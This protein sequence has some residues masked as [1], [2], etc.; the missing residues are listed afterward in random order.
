MEL[1][2]IATREGRAKDGCVKDGRSKDGHVNGV[3]CE[4]MTLTSDER[5]PVSSDDVDSGKASN[6]EVL[7]SSNE[8]SKAP[9]VRL[10]SFHSRSLCDSDMSSLG[11][12]DLMLGS[13]HLSDQS[14]AD[15]HCSVRSGQTKDVRRS[16]VS[17]SRNKKTGVQ[18]DVQHDLTCVRTGVQQL[19]QA[20][21][22]KTG[23][24]EDCGDGVDIPAITDAFHYRPTSERTRHRYSLP[25]D[26]RS[27]LHFYPS[28]TNQ[29]FYP[30]HTN[31]PF[32]PSHTFQHN[33]QP[34]RQHPIITGRQQTVLMDW[35]MYTGLMNEISSYKGMLAVLHNILLQECADSKATSDA[36]PVVQESCVVNETPD[37]S[38]MLDCERVALYEREIKRL[39]HA[40][41]DRDNV[42]T[43]LHSKLAIYEEAVT[44]VPCS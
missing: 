3:K 13:I 36:D 22:D 9:L 21:L 16:S 42:I 1:P 28:H 19:G 10:D 17:D 40:V 34:T 39:R 29:P 14:L 5:S 20:Y 15:L 4:G 12:Q 2:E 32:Y 8:T 26:D 25:T 6:S 43:L 30:S 37:T 7:L 11:S 23:E 24:Q 27:M 31:Q 35:N 38:A 41:T 44:L 18:R 33:T